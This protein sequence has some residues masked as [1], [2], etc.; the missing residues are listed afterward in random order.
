MSES[1]SQANEGSASFVPPLDAVLEALADEFESWAA[2]LGIESTY[3]D[4]VLGEEGSNEWASW[5]RKESDWALRTAG[6]LLAAKGKAEV[7][8]DLK[9]RIGELYPAADAYEQ[10]LEAMEDQ[11]RVH[12]EGIV[13]RYRQAFG[14]EDPDAA[15]LY[16]LCQGIQRTWTLRI[17]DD[18]PETPEDFAE[19]IDRAWFEEGGAKR[20]AQAEMKHRADQT[21]EHLR[22][23]AGIESQQAKAHT[24]AASEKGKNKKGGKRGPAPMRLEQ[25]WRY[26]TVV[27]EWTGIS[28]SNTNLSTRDRKRK[29]QLAE[30]HGITIRE[31]NAMLGWYAKHKREKRFPDDPRTLSRGEL[32]QWFA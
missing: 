5:L 25:A 8:E 28:E 3:S 6:T 9:R 10:R 2:G 32:K 20:M 4:P 24:A 11:R 1:M 21:V 7:A 14:D 12:V 26:V 22:L 27:Q 16:G 19:A 23:L 30:Q 13:A 29:V 15:R 17:D 31:L 18:S